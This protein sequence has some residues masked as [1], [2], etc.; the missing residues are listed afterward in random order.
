MLDYG[1]NERI[2][3]FTM[4][5]LVAFILLHFFMA[6]KFYSYGFGLDYMYYYHAARGNY[7]WV[8]KQPWYDD[9][10]ERQK[11]GI[12]WLYNDKLAIL[13]RPFIYLP[14]KMGMFLWMFLM[15]VS[16]FILIKKVMEVPYGWLAVLITAKPATILLV[17]GNIAPLLALLLITP[18]GL[19]LAPIFKPYLVLISA[20]HSGRHAHTKYGPSRKG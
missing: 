2:R 11:A 12:G 5:F 15:C 7:E 14:E 18:V 9:Y 13:W 8:E 20:I 1:K 10:D 3:S 6:W 17:T 19:F 16:Y 4:G